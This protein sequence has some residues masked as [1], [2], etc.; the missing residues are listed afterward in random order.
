MDRRTRPPALLAVSLVLA[1]SL[2]LLSAGGL[3]ARSAINAASADPG[4]SYDR[5]ILATLEGPAA[6]LLKAERTALNF[7]GRLSGVATQAARLKRM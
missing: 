6:S 5:A 4:F 2:G 3:F 7:L 1:L